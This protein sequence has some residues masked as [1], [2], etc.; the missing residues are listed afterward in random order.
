MKKLTTACCV[1][2]A[3]LLLVIGT[4]HAQQPNVLWILTDDQRYDSIE[5]FNR[6][7]HDRDR[8]ELGY[9][10]SPNVDRLAAMG[11]TFINT[12]C[13]APGCAPSRASMHY[14]RYP[15]RSGVYEFE[16]HNNN[17]EHCQPTLPEQMVTLGY[18][19]LHIGKLG[20]RIRTVKNGK[21]QKYPI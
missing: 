19:T 14:G 16:Y 21:A 9:V 15:F 8:S 10:E 12:Y 5:A 11:T 4:A 2:L 1:A 3:G 18:Q 13:Q 7:L 20:V 17:A 6:I